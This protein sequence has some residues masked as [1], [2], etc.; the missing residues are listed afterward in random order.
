VSAKVTVFVLASWSV[1]DD[2][3]AAAAMA[4]LARVRVVSAEISEQLF[5]ILHARQLSRIQKRLIQ[6]VWNITLLCK[7]VG[8]GLGVERRWLVQP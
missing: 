7:E 2:A 8:F 1:V 5:H 3:V 4:D 6:T